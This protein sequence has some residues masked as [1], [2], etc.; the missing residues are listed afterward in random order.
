LENGEMKIGKDGPVQPSKKPLIKEDAFFEKD[1]SATWLGVA[2]ILGL[3]M[4]VGAIS[5]VMTWK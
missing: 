3:I 4:L 2:L 5:G 1:G